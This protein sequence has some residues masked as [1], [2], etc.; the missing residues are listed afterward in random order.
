MENK[1]KAKLFYEIHA[2]P[3]FAAEEVLE[4]E[5]IK[6]LQDRFLTIDPKSNVEVEYARIRGSIE[7]LKDLKAKREHLIEEARSRSRNS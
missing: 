1:H 7:A 6:S 2:H 5:I 3:A 4:Q